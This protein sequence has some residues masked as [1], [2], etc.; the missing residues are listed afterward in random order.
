MPRCPTPRQRCCGTSTW[1]T[2]SAA[3]TAAG[4]GARVVFLPELTLSRYPA[5]ALPEGRPDATA[6]SLEDGPTVTFA[7]EAA[8]ASGVTSAVM[9]RDEGT[10]VP[11]E[12][13]S[14]LVPRNEDA[15]R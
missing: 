3:A 7:R 2:P 14:E 13:A 12:V 11:V 10:I 6:E 15:N 4:A 8:A 1:P 5:D 9:P